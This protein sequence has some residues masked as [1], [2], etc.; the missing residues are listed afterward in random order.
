VPDDTPIDIKL[1]VDEFKAMN[2]DLSVE[3]SQVRDS[4]V[5]TGFTFL[6]HEFTESGLPHRD[7]YEVLERLYVP[8]RPQ[9]GNIAWDRGRILAAVIQNPLSQLLW[10]ICWVVWESFDDNF[11][12]DDLMEAFRNPYLLGDD[13]WD[14]SYAKLLRRSPDGKLHLPEYGDVLSLYNERPYTTV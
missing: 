13:S 10:Y 8:E 14:P 11:M 3:K 7:I 6:S 2:L 9:R 1:L 12:Y 4:I 5:G